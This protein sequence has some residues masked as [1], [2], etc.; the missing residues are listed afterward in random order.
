MAGPYQLQVQHYS[1]SRARAMDG[2]LD[3]LVTGEG[4][5]YLEIATV[6]DPLHLHPRSGGRERNRLRPTDM[7]GNWLFET[8]SLVGSRCDYT[9]VIFYTK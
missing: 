7:L 4:P 5:M 9:I 3:D 6:I 8:I 2:V 1:M